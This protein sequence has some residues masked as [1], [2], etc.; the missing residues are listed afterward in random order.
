MDRRS[1]LSLASIAATFGLPRKGRTAEAGLVA[2]DVLLEPD[3][4]LA[5]RARAL[6][7]QIRPSDARGFA[8]DATHV[9]HVTL[10]QQFVR[11]G[12]VARLGDVVAM[13][14][15]SAPPPS[16][17]NVTGLEFSSW[18]GGVMVSIGIER[19]GMLARLQAALVASLIPFVAPAGDASAFVRDPPETQIDAATLDYVSG[20]LLKRT[21]ENYEP[22]VTVGVASKAAAEGLKAKPFERRS[23]GIARVAAYQIGNGGTARRRL[24]PAT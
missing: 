13:A 21:G 1:L 17:L 2:I 10:I 15:E 5:E 22:H 11:Q 8:L 9:P 7:A 16:D 19:S 23:Y 20:F 3:A 24:W 12:D 14:L 4:A 18:N 6:N